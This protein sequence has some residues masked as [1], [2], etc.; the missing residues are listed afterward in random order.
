M[1]INGIEVQGIRRVHIEDTVGRAQKV[2]CREP[3]DEGGFFWKQ[4]IPAIKDPCTG[5]LIEK[6][7]V[8]LDLIRWV[9][10]PYAGYTA[11]IK[12]DTIYVKV[13][14]W[15]DIVWQWGSENE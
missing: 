7:E 13:S 14:S 9:F 15:R 3:V 5:P 10:S 8:I 1:K 6:D 11:R 4:V 12:G 2:W